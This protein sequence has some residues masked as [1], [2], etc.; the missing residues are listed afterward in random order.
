MSD[1]LREKKLVVFTGELFNLLTPADLQSFL[2]YTF[3]FN[4]C[5]SVHFA[6]LFFAKENQLLD[7][8]CLCHRHSTITKNFPNIIVH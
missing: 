1:N 8:F 2:N 4:L 7:H 3:W 6:K 5:F